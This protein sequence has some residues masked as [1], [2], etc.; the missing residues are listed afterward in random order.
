MKG[1]VTLRKRGDYRT[2]KEY[3]AHFGVSLEKIRDWRKK[4]YRIDRLLEAASL[5]RDAARI[6][7]P[8]RII[9]DYDVDGITSGAGLVRIAKKAGAKD[10]K[11][12]VPCRYDDGYGANP[13]QVKSC[14]D[15]CLLILVDNGDR[16]S[17]V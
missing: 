14:P 1:T 11:L 4:S 9:A 5:I 3:I 12:C 17:V 16:K 10:V 2:L 7:I 6:G 15:G 8:V 13:E